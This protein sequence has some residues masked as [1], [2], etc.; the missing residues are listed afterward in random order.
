MSRYYIGGTGIS[1]EYLIEDTSN[2]LIE[3][4]D[5]TSNNLIEYVDDTSNTLY[6]LINSNIIISNNELLSLIQQNSNNIDNNSS[7]L[8]NTLDFIGDIGQ[9]LTLLFP[10]AQNIVDVIQGINDITHWDTTGGKESDNAIIYEVVGGV[11]M[12]NIN[13]IPQ[14]L[15]IVEA[16]ITL[17]SLP[18]LNI[19][20]YF[21]NHNDINTTIINIQKLLEE[22]QIRISCSEFAST[23]KFQDQV[24][25]FLKWGAQLTS[26]WATKLAT[27]LGYHTATSLGYARL[28]DYTENVQDA[29]I[30][31]CDEDFSLI[32]II[33]AG[34][35]GYSIADLFNGAQSYEKS[36]SE[37]LFLETSNT[38]YS[39]ILSNMEDIS[40]IKGD[41]LKQHD[42]NVLYN[43]IQ[44]NNNNLTYSITNIQNDYL[45]HEDSNI[46]YNLI[47]INTNNLNIIQ[48]DYLTSINSNT[49][50]SNIT[51][52]DTKIDNINTEIN[53]TI[54]GLW[55]V[56]GTTIYQLTKNI[57]IGTDVVS[58]SE[59]LEINGNVKIS[60]NLI[61]NNFVGIGTTTPSIY[62][63]QQ[64]NDLF[65]KFEVVGNKS[66]I[67]NLYIPNDNNETHSLKVEK[68]SEFQNLDIDEFLRVKDKA[69]VSSNLTV[70][71][72][73]IDANYQLKIDG[74]SAMGNDVEDDFFTDLDIFY[75]TTPEGLYNYNTK[76][77]ITPTG[78]YKWSYNNMY[79][80]PYYYENG[81]VKGSLSIDYSKS[82]IFTI[83]TWISLTNP[84]NLQGFIPL[85]RG[86]NNLDQ[87]IFEIMLVFDQFNQKIRLYD[88]NNNVLV[89]TVIPSNI[90]SNM[91]NFNPN[92]FSF[93][94]GENTHSFSIYINGI[95]FFSQNNVINTLTI[96]KIVIGKE[97]LLEASAISLFFYNDVVIKSV[98][99]PAYKIMNM[100]QYLA[101]LYE[102]KLKVNGL[103]H[104]DIINC[105]FLRYKNQQFLPNNISNFLT[106][107]SKNSISIVRGNIRITEFE[108]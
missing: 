6:E 5:N 57:G 31:Q 32:Y 62:N 84:V 56:N 52:L 68:L 46:L 59:K 14:P 72:N 28:D 24:D 94:F 41:Y 54:D 60:S 35:T 23:I 82:N 63:G 48:S 15:W 100:Y 12:V 93:V 38:F 69:Y 50:F 3:Y 18:P 87:L 71:Q 33:L 13:T 75:H 80:I 34:L 92:M 19:Y 70:G 79:L 61:T 7:T 66:K 1:I 91:D 51:S 64:G 40:L 74:K 99:L 97:D 2:T 16:F 39:N 96:N 78:F 47:E 85:F 36:T 95:N 10:E 107:A 25:K 4:I 21:K 89:E 76:N 67:D 105:K 81:V 104:A 103:L 83:T 44:T 45:Q 30:D 29:L 65:Y 101:S 43:L 102:E 27:R 8:S 17:A 98:A 58:E 37:A 86:F 53:N 11:R 108:N 90:V 49:L 42:S 55:S 22:H 9:D 20:N 73:Q 88:N 106:P 77:I 26:T